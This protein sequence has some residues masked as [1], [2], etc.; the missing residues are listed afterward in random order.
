MCANLVE[1]EVGQYFPSA[2]LASW[3]TVMKTETMQLVKTMDHF[4]WNH[5][6]VAS[7]ADVEAF[8]P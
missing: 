6:Q 2:C 3:T 4:V 8:V 7:G 1:L 5:F